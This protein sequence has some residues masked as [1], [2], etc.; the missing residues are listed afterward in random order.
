VSQKV[1]YQQK[2]EDKRGRVQEETSFWINTFV[3]KTGVEAICMRISDLNDPGLISEIVYDFPVDCG[4][5]LNFLVAQLPA[6]FCRELM[7][8]PLEAY[9]LSI[10]YEPLQLTILQVSASLAVTDRHPVLLHGDLIVPAAAR[11][12]VEEILASQ[13]DVPFTWSELISVAGFPAAMAAFSDLWDQL[14][15]PKLS[16]MLEAWCSTNKYLAL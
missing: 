12:T 1:S 9:R 15:G 5:T 4:E 14:V 16:P 11:A 10:D 2:A 3:P 8:T 7:V 6:A 13:I